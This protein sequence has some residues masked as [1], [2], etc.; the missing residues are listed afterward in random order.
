MEKERKIFARLL[1]E[2]FYIFPELDRLPKPL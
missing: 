2:T 1:S